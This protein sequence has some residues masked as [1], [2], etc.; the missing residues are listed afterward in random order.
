MLKKNT[1]WKQNRT[2][3]RKLKVSLSNRD[4]ARVSY[5]RVQKEGSVFVY[6]VRH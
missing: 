5:A 1:G 6:A 4:A 2:W 3:A